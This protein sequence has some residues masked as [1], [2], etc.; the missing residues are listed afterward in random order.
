MKLNTFQAAG[1][2]TQPERLVIANAPDIDQAMTS[3]EW[4][5]SSDWRE[6]NR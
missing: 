2:A 4:I 1:S 6:A 5:S 3:G